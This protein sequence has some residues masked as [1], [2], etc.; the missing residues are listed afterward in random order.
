MTLETFIRELESLRE[1]L[2]RM[3]CLVES[4]IHDAV[5]ALLRLD[6]TA[7]DKVRMGDRQVNELRRQLGEQA[8]EA[9]ARQHPNGR[10]LRMLMGIQLMAVELERLGDYAVHIARRTWT[11][12]ELPRRPLPSELGLLGEL[13]VEQVRQV[14]DALIEHSPARALEVAARDDELDRLYHRA[15][16]GLV[17]DMGPDAEDA[18]RTVTLI[19]VAHNLERIGDR[20]VNVA[21]DV[22]FLETGD[23]VDLG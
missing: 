10:E 11:I 7:A 9:I 23:V 12:A 20:V 21:E 17:H 14:L 18:L 16:E 22:A 5:G 19:Q 6:R 4:Q 8:L 13:A 2:L 1:S 15:F 3:A